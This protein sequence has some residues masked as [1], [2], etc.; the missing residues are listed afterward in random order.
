[1]AKKKKKDTAL[2]FTTVAAFPNNAAVLGGHLA[3]QGE[4]PEG[5]RLMVINKESWT[6][7][8]DMMDIVYAIA[9]RRPQHDPAALGALGREELYRE[10]VF[11]GASRDIAI[12]KSEEGYL[13]DLTAIGDVMYAC[14]AQGQVY[15]LRGS[16]WQ[17]ID[18]GLRVEFNGE[19]VERMLLGIAGF[20]H[21][22]LYVCGFD[23]EV[24]RYDG[25]KWTELDSPTNLPLNAVLCAPDKLVYFCGESGHLFALT[26]DGSWDDLTDEEFADAE[27]SDLTWFKDRL[28]IAADD[29]L[30][31]L[32]GRKVKAV[33]N[34]SK[35]EWRILNIDAAPD[36]IWCVGGEETLDYDGQKWT[37]HV[38]PE[39][40]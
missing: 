22:D 4:D 34:P 10:F 2:Y 28:W 3:I 35:G 9:I 39:N 29:R 15:R 7:L 19:D 24:W 33:K 11:G 26:R 25:K 23:G 32:D 40:E 20:S 37:S 38:C 12:N 21:D 1:M 16:R 27:F 36:R 6:H 5:T 18:K 30:L 31:Y 8:G 13:E 14:G 17:A